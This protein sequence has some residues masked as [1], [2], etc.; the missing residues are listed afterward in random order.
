MIKSAFHIVLFLAL[1]H[2][3]PVSAQTKLCTAGVIEYEKTVNM[4]D[5]IQRKVDRDNSAFMQP[6][7]DKYKQE[8]DRFRK[9][10]SSLVFTT[11]RTF[12][13]PK[14]DAGTSAAFFDNDA[15]VGQPN[16]VFHDLGSGLAVTQKQLFGET[17][18]VKDSM[19]KITWKITDETREIAGFTCRRA[20]GLIMDSVY[21][22]AF[23]T[24]RIPVAG[25][26][27]SFSG[28]P[29]MILGVALPHLHITWFAT[30]VIEKQPSP[31]NIQPPVQGRPLDNQ[32]LRKKMN[33]LLKGPEAYVYF[34]LIAYLL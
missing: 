7:I 6:A 23:Y 29:G 25:G 1:L 33:D 18:L 14:E 20:N 11:T 2:T 28:L 15:A 31:N 32:G 13:S 24:N 30:S 34:S 9:A 12:Y 26:P 8:H 21:V 5:F 4:Y 19:R 22:V 27:E 3:V 17:F 16:H 10:Q